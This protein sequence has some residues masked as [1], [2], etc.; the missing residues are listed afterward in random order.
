MPTIDQEAKASSIII[1]TAAKGRSSSHDPEN[2]LTNDIPEHK[3]ARKPG[4]VIITTGAVIA[5]L[6][7]IPS[8]FMDK[9]CRLVLRKWRDRE[10]VAREDRYLALDSCDEITALLESVNHLT[11][12]QRQQN[13]KRGEQH[14]DS[15]RSFYRNNIPGVCSGN[16]FGL[17]AAGNA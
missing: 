10:G 12:R 5:V 3:P 8:V 1:Q 9:H 4:N 6:L 16:Y 14:G 13:N 15:P 2:S 11:G 17:P 7:G